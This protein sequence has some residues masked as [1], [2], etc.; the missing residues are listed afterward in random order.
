MYDKYSQFY[1]NGVHSSVYNLFYVNETGGL[2]YPFSPSFTQNFVTPMYQGRTYFLGTDLQQ[3]TYNLTLAA[4]KLSNSE[5]NAIFDW[6]NI[7][8]PSYITFD[9]FPNYSQL[10]VITSI[11]ESTIY[12]K[13]WR[14]GLVENIIEFTITL[15]S[16][17]DPFPKT[18]TL[19]LAREKNKLIRDTQTKLPIAVTTEAE[20]T[21][22][23]FKVLN[24]T[25]IKQYVTLNLSGSSINVDGNLNTLYQIKGYPNGG[26]YGVRLDGETGIGLITSGASQDI[27]LLVDT[28]ATEV[29]SNGPLVIPVGLVFSGKLKLD[30]SKPN[31]LTQYFEVPLTGSY[32]IAVLPPTT[33]ISNT[34]EYS[35]H[36]DTEN[37]GIYPGEGGAAHLPFTS[38][39]SSLKIPIVDRELNSWVLPGEQEY[40]VLVTKPYLIT[41]TGTQA[42]ATLEMSYRN[43]L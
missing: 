38:S 4:S 14:N 1:Y 18:K 43:R 7:G 16:V 33:P 30:L 9:A 28:K 35:L 20:G 27:G 37:K 8:K 36:T 5:L 34:V 25:S 11:G 3:T 10:V 42:T 40:H 21:R 22:T 6:L 17:G 39:G 12:P 15:E 29:I 24:W 23:V 31:D 13:E 26:N 19:T 32:E 2:T 41:V